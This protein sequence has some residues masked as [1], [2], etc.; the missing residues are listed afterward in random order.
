M[1]PT[2]W[3]VPGIAGPYAL[4][5]AFAPAFDAALTFSSLS[6]SWARLIVLSSRATSMVL[7][8]DGLGVD[9]ALD[10]RGVLGPVIDTLALRARGRHFHVA[11]GDQGVFQDGARCGLVVRPGHVPECGA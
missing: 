10:L 8:L 1:T 5:L 6:F 4:A 11:E 9:Q 7:L 3:Q 2:A